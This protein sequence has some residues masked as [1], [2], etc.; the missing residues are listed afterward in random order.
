MHWSVNFFAGIACMALAVNFFAAAYGL[1]LGFKPLPTAAVS[2]RDSLG[3]WRIPNPEEAARL[4][5]PL[6]QNNGT[7][8]LIPPGVVSR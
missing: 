3:Q 6:T 2:I 7:D 5:I 8:N 4:N 1:R